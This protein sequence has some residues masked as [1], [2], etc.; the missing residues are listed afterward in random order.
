MQKG[1][2]WWEVAGTQGIVN[3]AFDAAADTNK[4]MI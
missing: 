3:N 1:G 4:L 2:G